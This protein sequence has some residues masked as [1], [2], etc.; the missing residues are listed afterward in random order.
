MTVTS[1]VEM[2][3]EH[4]Q[5]L[6]RT[7]PD[8]L[9]TIPVA[10]FGDSA[11]PPVELHVDC[12]SEAHIEVDADAQGQGTYHGRWQVDGKFVICKLVFEKVNMR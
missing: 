11:L 2:S 4:V 9:L 1:N 3:I 5:E 7:G 6:W 8:R 12:A 10:S